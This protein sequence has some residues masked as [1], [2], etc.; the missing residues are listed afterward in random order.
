MLEMDLVKIWYMTPVRLHNNIQKGFK[1]RPVF[2]NEVTKVAATLFMFQKFCEKPNG[3]VF[4]LAK[5]G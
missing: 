2:E 1:Y 3:L 5:Y 4:S